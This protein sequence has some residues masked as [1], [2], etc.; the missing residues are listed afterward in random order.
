[1]DGRPVEPGAKD[2]RVLYQVERLN[3]SL[4]ART[5]AREEKT[6][7]GAT[8]SGHSLKVVLN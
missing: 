5:R 4:E 8:H 3:H 6:S 2:Y 1:M 7:H